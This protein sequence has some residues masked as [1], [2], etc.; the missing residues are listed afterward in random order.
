M[1]V[2]GKRDDITYAGRT[3]Y[4]ELC[5]LKEILVSDLRQIVDGVENGLV[6]IADVR[7]TF[8]RQY[9]RINHLYPGFDEEVCHIRE[10][11]VDLLTVDSQ[12]QFQIDRDNYQR[13]KKRKL[14][15]QKR[16]PQGPMEN[17]GGW[18]LDTK[19]YDFDLD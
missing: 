13:S 12:N 19:M 16:N 18:N 15:K 7:D 5:R 6:K 9:Q 10:K 8:L 14:K 1:A 3:F 17:I 11:Y 2:I 4:D